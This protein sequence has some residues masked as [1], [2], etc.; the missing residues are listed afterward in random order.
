[1]GY[2]TY[3]RLRGT[4]Q[5]QQQQQLSGPAGIILVLLHDHSGVLVVCVCASV[6]VVSVLGMK[7]LFFSAREELC[8]NS[9]K[10]C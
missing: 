10:I 1:M 9:S 5:Q 6:L 3:Q 2:R 7:P 4:T 8:L